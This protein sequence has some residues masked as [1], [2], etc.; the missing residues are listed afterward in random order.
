MNLSVL[1]PTMQ[2]KIRVTGDCWIWTGAKNNKGYGSVTNGHGGSMLAHRK[3][4]TIAKGH[5]PEGMTID[6]ICEVKAC[7]NPDHLQV[8]S[9]AL[10]VEMV[11]VRA[12]ARFD[13]AHPRPIGPAAPDFGLLV[14]V[15]HIETNLARGAEGLPYLP[16]PT[17]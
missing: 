8:M 9:R 11:G 7:V 6:H 16:Y 10:N 13:A 2:S 12:Q 14:F 17:K 1:P 5:I 3:A 4:Y 15:E